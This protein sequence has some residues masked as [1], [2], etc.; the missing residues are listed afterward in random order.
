MDSRNTLNTL[1]K[2]PYAVAG[3]AII[4]AII[5]LWFTATDSRQRE[6][7]LEE[8]QQDLEIVNQNEKSAK[9]LSEDLANLDKFYEPIKN[10]L[11]DLNNTTEILAYLLRAEEESG[12]NM[13][14]PKEEDISPLKILAD[15]DYAD[16]KPTADDRM[17]AKYEL[18]IEGTFPGVLTFIDK[19]FNGPYFVKIPSF[20]MGRETKFSPK[21]VRMA[22][23]MSILGRR[24]SS[25]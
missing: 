9:G 8:L 2:Y 18:I 4:V 23:N 3:I 7:A 15:E 11:V 5:A 21:H 25:E 22:F 10:R 1:S 24:G 19:V 16:F 12:V 14:D 6:F 13:Q 17:V 20:E